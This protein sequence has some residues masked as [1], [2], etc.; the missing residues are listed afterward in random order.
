MIERCG[1]PNLGAP[2]L[3]KL[4]YESITYLVMVNLAELLI[5]TVPSPFNVR[6]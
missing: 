2:H 1:A 5:E 3:N 6:T 4:A